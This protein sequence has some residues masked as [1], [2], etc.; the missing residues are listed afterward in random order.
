MLRAKKRQRGGKT[1]ARA[2][3]RIRNQ[4]RRK[5]NAKTHQQQ[6]RRNDENYR[7]LNIHSAR[8]RPRKML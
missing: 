6:G 7:V 3:T 1:H 4:A 8:A 5:I 2:F